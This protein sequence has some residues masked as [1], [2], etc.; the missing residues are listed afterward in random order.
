MKHFDQALKLHPKIA[1][2]LG[3]QGLLL[4]RKKKLSEGIL[5]L[6]DAAEAGD[7]PEIA[8]DLKLAL[9]QLSP[10]EKDSEKFKPANKASGLLNVKYA[11]LLGDRQFKDFIPIPLNEAPG[12]AGKQAGGMW[13]GT[14]FLISAEGLILTNRHVVEGS[15][16]LMVML[17]GNVQKTGEVV[18]IDDQQDLAL[19]R[20]KADAPLPFVKL[21]PHDA[22]GIGAE[23]TVMG[24]PLL[25]RLGVNIK[26][27]R[28][29]VTGIEPVELNQD[30]IVDA[31]VNPGNSGGP[32]LDKHGNVLAIVSM[33]TLST[34][35]EDTYGLGLSS[36]HIRKFLTKNKITLESGDEG[37]ANLS[38]EDIAAKVRPAAV[39]ILSTR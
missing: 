23:C 34:T 7:T 16:T 39:C 10:R 30:V 37:G 31:K 1:A 27:T 33:K 36:G 38:S 6:H 28:G 18:M 5:K 12:S 13:S 11:S 24:F 15:K 19:I 22:P 4:I 2:A 26:I 32:I 20:V 14:G 25:D 8:V 9:S 17:D 29:V 3:N 21:S 35:T